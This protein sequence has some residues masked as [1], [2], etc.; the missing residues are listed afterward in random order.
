[1]TPH[2]A[3]DPLAVF[4]V[5]GTFLRPRPDAVVIDWNDPSSV[6][7]ALM[8]HRPA[9]Q[10]VARTKGVR[11]LYVA[12][13]AP[14]LGDLTSQQVHD[15][16][17]PF[18]PVI[19]IEEA[20]TVIAPVV[21]REVETRSKARTLAEIGVVLGRPA[22]YVGDKVADEDAAKAANVPFVYAEGFRHF[23]EHA[24]DVEAGI[25]AKAF[26]HDAAAIRLLARPVTDNDR[27]FPP[28]EPVAPA[29]PSPTHC[30]TSP[31]CDRAC[32]CGCAGCKAAR[33]AGVR[34]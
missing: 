33:A 19:H 7:D 34:P 22:L 30:R 23:A 21:Q 5:D 16:G 2:K 9:C 8:Y 17:L 18:A 12:W 3:Q 26:E 4:E 28:P 20:A 31:W 24:K 11:I 13:R 25:P 29:R 15:A 32:G 27:R 14:H 10:L 6:R 1:M